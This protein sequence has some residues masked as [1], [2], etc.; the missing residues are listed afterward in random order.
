MFSARKRVF[1]G[2]GKLHA[3]PFCPIITDESG[4]EGLARALRTISPTKMS[5][6]KPTRR[7]GRYFA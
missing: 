6:N 4:Y 3:K 1:A 5:P 7:D 2:K